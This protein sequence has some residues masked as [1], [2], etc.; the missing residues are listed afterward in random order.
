MSTLKKI[1][2]IIISVTLIAAASATA[3]AE[4]YFSDGKFE[5]I[6]T[7]KGNGLIT[8]CELTKPCINVPEFVLD[9]PIAGIYDYAFMEVPTLRR[10]TMPLSIVSIGEFAFANNSQTFIVKIPKY[11]S[12]I[13]STAFFHSPNAVIVGRSDS[14]AAQYAADNNIDFI[15]EEDYILGDVNGDRRLSI[16]DVTCIQL[17]LV[18]VLGYELDNKK[19]ALADVNADGKVNIRDATCIQMFKV[20]LIKDFDNLT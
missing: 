10:I 20:D 17:Y 8:G 4:T 1:I 18:E 19:M 7:D 11:C 9:Y 15:S 16:R 14:Y 5:F 6:K 12:Q 2:A 13:D 3:M